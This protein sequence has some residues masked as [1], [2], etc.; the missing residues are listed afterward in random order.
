MSINIRKHIETKINESLTDKEFDQFFKLSEFVEVKKK[1][2]IVVEGQQSKFLFFIEKGTLHSFVT[3]E[4]GENHTIQFGFEGHWI[5]DL[6]SFL[7]DKPAIFT[8]EALEATTLFAIRQTDFERICRQVPKFE[9][10][11]RILIQ[12]AYVNSQQRI[13]KT[14]SEDA[15]NRY[16]ALIKQ[17]PDLLQR[18]PQYL[19]ASYLGIKP[20]S[21]SRIRKSYLKK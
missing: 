15:G 5:A 18:V 10:F 2:Q 7:S 21:L 14:F 9:H 16:L 20:E 17:Q 4:Q 3:D 12:N 19:V 8:I 13:A 11:F 6:Y 1:Q